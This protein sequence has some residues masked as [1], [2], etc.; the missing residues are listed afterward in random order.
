LSAP[1]QEPSTDWQFSDSGYYLFGARFG[2]RDEIKGMVDCG[3]LGYLGIAAHGH[4]DALALVL[5][6][7]GEECL[8]DSGTYS[9][10]GEYQWRDYF[11]G[12]AAHNT[13]RVDGVD[14]SVSGGRFMWTHKAKSQVERMPRSPAPFD[15]IGS[16]DGYLRLRDPVH[17][18]RSVTFDDAQACLFVKDEVWG[19][20]AHAVE[21]FWHFAPHIRVELT[22]AGAV[23][24]GSRFALHMQF[25]PQD[26]ALELIRGRENPPLGWY[27]RGYGAKEPATVLRAR[28]ASSAVV[29]EVTFAISV[30]NVAG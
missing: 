30:I 23:A 6:I 13:I 7:A 10:G 27:S 16:H 15:F 3:P 4:A 11:R 12:T 24:R 2:E 20:D 14:Q 1:T 21:Q 26:L 25:S 22:G 5:S 29:I 17:H 18:R 8:V 19:K 9:Y 28:A